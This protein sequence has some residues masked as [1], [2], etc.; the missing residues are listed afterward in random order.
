VGK[1]FILQVFFP[2]WHSQIAVHQLA[3]VHDCHLPFTGCYSGE[4]GGDSAG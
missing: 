4:C 3:Q 1:V 2:D